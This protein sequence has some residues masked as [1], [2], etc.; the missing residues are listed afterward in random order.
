MLDMPKKLLIVDDDISILTVLSQ[1]FAELGYCVRS[2]EDGLSALSEIKNELP[3]I[4]LSDLNMAGISG[5][6]FLLI[7]RRMFPS[8]RVAAMSGAYSGND[9][10]PGVAA[11]AFYEKGSR[12]HLLTQV[13][14]TMTRPGCSTMRLGTEDLLRFRVRGKIPSHPYSR[15]K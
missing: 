6:Q 15:I 12:L 3:D 11:D 4:L 8:I 2:A 14:D 10:P 5:V 1:H 13:V 7:V 9:V